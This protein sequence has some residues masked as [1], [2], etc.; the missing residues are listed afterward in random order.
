[1]TRQSKQWPPSLSGSYKRVS[2][3]SCNM[4]QR[5]FVVRDFPLRNVR[6]NSVDYVF[7]LRTL[8]LWSWTYP[9]Q[10]RTMI[11]YWS[12][13]SKWK[14]TYPGKSRHLVKI[15][16]NVK[17]EHNCCWGTRYG[18]CVQNLVIGWSGSIFLRQHYFGLL[19]KGNST[20]LPNQ[21]RSI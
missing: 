10:W 17:D 21:W 14:A 20:W 15:S 9:A 11:K 2:M 6:G 16:E 1:M 3:H 13:L 18:A 19:Y 5:L 7:R 4:A 12:F 8:H